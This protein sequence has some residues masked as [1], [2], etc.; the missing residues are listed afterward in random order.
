MT[1]PAVQIPSAL[2]ERAQA[3]MRLPDSYVP[4]LEES[5]E[6]IGALAI[7]Y[8]RGAGFAADGTP[9]ATASAVIVKAGA[10]LAANTDQTRRNVGNTSIRSFFDEWDTVEKKLLDSL[11]RT[12][13]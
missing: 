5:L 9:G 12:A 11:R 13:R 10:R 4:M 2:V 6:I 7:D 1:L 8:T 3:F